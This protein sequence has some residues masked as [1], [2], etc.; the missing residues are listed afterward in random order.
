MARIS[1]TRSS[2]LDP[3]TTLFIVASK[4]F[5]TDETMTNA[6]FG[7]RLDR[8]CAGRRGGARPFR[9]ALDQPQGLRR[10][11]HPPGPHL[12]VL[13]LGRRPLLGLVGHRPAGRHRRR[14]STISRRSCA[15]PTRWTSISSR[16]RSRRTCRSSWALLGVW[17]RNAWGFSTHAVLPY[18]QRLSRFAAYL[19]Q[20]DMESNGKSVTLE[21]KPVD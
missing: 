20:Q 8:R 12:R 17:Y 1:T 9:G 16:P 11:R 18:D 15:A 7:A 2:G 10:L 4:T 21:G 14:L 13:G 3:A 5:T 6:A 19:Q